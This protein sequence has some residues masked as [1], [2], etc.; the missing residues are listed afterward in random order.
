MAEV[1]DAGWE[2]RHGE[3][4]N[5]ILLLNFFCEPQA[6]LKIS[7]LKRRSKVQSRSY[8]SQILCPT[9]LLI[10]KVLLSY[11]LQTSVSLSVK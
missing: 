4:L 5:L 2:R 6:A 3:P 7:L 11:K 9:L 8:K 1:A 10:Y